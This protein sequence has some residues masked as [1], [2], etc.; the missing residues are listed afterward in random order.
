M[1]KSLTIHFDDPMLRFFYVK[2]LQKIYSDYFDFPRE[3]QRM[4]GIT[5]EV[6]DGM[7]SKKIFDGEGL[8]QDSI[9]KTDFDED[10][11]DKAVKKEKERNREKAKFILAKEE[12]RNA[13]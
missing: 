6:H 13:K 2:N 11:F 7:F 12:E 4:Y 3:Y 8:L 5:Y 10:L 9:N 1:K